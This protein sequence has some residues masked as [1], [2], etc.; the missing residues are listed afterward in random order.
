MSL[1]VLKGHPDA[2][3]PRGTEYMVVSIEDRK[4]TMVA[5]GTCSGQLPLDL[6]PGLYKAVFTKTDPNDP[7]RILMR[8]YQEFYVDVDE[9]EFKLL[10]GLKPKFAKSL[11]T[12]D[13]P[14][15]S[16]QIGGCDFSG[17]TVYAMVA[18]EAKHQGFDLSKEGDRARYLVD[19]DP[20]VRSAS[21][22]AEPEAKGKLILK[23]P[24]PPPKPPAKPTDF[25]KPLK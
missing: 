5:E 23:D 25:T 9:S 15:F 14:R 7:K 8:H 6:D 24:P 11:Q 13:G 4:H 22:K 18:H 1:I 10:K 12:S 20:M 21:E 2:G 16:C 3:I 17:M 19:R